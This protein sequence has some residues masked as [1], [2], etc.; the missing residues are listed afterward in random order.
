MISF[1]CLTYLKYTAKS[2]DKMASSK[3]LIT[4]VYSS[5]ETLDNNWFP[6]EFNII[7]H[8]SK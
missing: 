3:T 5:G 4:R 6:G 8:W 7:M 2:V 1:P